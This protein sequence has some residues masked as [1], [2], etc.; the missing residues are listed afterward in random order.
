MA[1]ALRD[2]C[3]HQA[4]DLTFGFDIGITALARQACVLW[5]L[6][7]PGLALGRLQGSVARRRSVVIP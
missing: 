1:L 2:C 7:H 4:P 6:G 3:P 5:L